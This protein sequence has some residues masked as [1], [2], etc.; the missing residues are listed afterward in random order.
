MN[1]RRIRIIGPVNPK[2]PTE[3][4][5]LQLWFLRRL[6][7]W[8]PDTDNQLVQIL[9][10]IWSY[11][12][13][14]FFLYAYTTTQI[15]FFLNVENLAVSWVWKCFFQRRDAKVKKFVILHNIQSQYELIS[16]TGSCRRIFSSSNSNYS[17]LQGRKVLQQSVS[18]QGFDEMFGQFNVQAIGRGWRCVWKLNFSRSP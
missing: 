3:S 1:N 7:L 12:Y 5:S 9:Y 14:W 11:F 16:F 6:G 17:H 2:T 4:F 8:A 13:R 15:L 18:N 10:T